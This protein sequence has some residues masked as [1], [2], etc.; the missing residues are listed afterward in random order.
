MLFVSYGQ[1]VIYR[2][3]IFKRIQNYQ[4][5]WQIEIIISVK[6]VT[7]CYEKICAMTV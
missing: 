5:T 4:G 1:K 7:E 6:N 2:R 3:T